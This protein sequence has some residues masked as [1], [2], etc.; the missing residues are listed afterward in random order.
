MLKYLLAAL[1]LTLHTAQA[2]PRPIANRLVIATFGGLLGRAVK[3]NVERF[4]RPLGIEVVIVE[5]ASADILAKLRAQKAAPQFDLALLNDQT[6]VVA[7]ALGL[8]EKLDPAEMPNARL[9]RPGLITPDGY[10]APYEI[11]PTGYVYRRDKLAE[12]GVTTLD[13]WRSVADPRLAG[14]VVTFTFASFYTPILMSGLEIS[15][16][17][18]LPDESEIWPFLETLHRNRTI[19]LAQP[20]QAEEL[21]KSGEAWV[22]PGTAERALLLRSQGVDIGFSPARDALLPLTN[23]MAPVRHAP[24]KVAAQRVL[25]WILG[26]EIQTRSAQDGAIVPVNAQVVLSPAQKARLGFDPDREIPSF[27]PIDVATLN[28]RFADLAEH[29]SKTMAP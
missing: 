12:A 17:K 29:F 15:K 20:G 10:G 9:L 11:N 21:A 4:T 25:N 6:F 14:R 1:L 7:K 27:I 3:E 28:D 13:T 8:I 19:V 22:Y 5:G 23:Y 24:H 2:Q 26:T 18:A 16:G